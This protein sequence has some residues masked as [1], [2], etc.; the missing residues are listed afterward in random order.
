MCFACHN[1][2]IRDTKGVFVYEFGPKLGIGMATKTVIFYSKKNSDM[3]R[4]WNVAEIKYLRYDL[5]T[6]AELH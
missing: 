4:I 5:E 1:Q 6:I 3:G 2:L